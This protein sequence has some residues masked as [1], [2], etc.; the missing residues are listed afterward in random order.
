MPMQIFTHTPLWVWALAL[1]LLT[2]GLWQRRTRDVAPAA[3]LGPPLGM[4]GLGLWTLVPGF[5][6]LPVTAMIWLLA[7]GGGLAL[8]PC[9][10]APRGTAWLPTTRR[11]HLP[12]SWLPLLV[13]SAVF[14][15]RYAAAVALV[16]NPALRF[17]LVFQA[18]LALSFGLLGG[19]FLGRA[20]GLLALGR[21]EQ[22]TM[23]RHAAAQPL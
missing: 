15:L 4:L 23:Q 18:T 6:Q 13:I 2:L 22:P 21:S 3:L 10:P 17:S 16:L 1:A 5:V 7:L 20:M 11:L 19:S 9:L 14:S 12:G 8:G